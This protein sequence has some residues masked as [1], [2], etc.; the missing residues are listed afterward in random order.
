MEKVELNKVVTSID[1]TSGQNVMITTRD[2]CEYSAAYVIF[3]GSL[4]VLKEKHSTMFIPPLPQKKQR[5]IEV[6]E[7]NCTSTDYRV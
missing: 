5:A 1:Y 7:R 2:G 3:T 6:R 4:G